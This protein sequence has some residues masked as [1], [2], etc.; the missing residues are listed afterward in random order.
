MQTPL[1]LYAISILLTKYDRREL[2]QSCVCSYYISLSPQIS[3]PELVL[4]VL[5]SILTTYVVY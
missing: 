2:V 5:L 1:K 3:I 4:L